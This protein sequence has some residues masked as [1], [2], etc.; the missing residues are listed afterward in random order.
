LA[1]AAVG[2][3]LVGAGCVPPPVPLEQALR[4]SM[5]A[6]IARNRVVTIGPSLPSKPPF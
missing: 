6:A 1:G 5:H 2:G 3:G 4:T